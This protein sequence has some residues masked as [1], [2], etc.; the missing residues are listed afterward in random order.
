M[1]SILP[2][3]NPDDHGGKILM[4]MATGRHTQTF[5]DRLHRP[6]DLDFDTIVRMRARGFKGPVYP[7]Q[8]SGGRWPRRP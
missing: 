1:Y 6:D 5:D 7:G 4:I 3:E 8:V 2:A